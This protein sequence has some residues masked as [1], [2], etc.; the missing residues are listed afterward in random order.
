MA[1]ALPILLQ[2]QLS[3]SVLHSYRLIFIGYFGLCLSVAALYLFLSPAVEVANQAGLAP[4]RTKI[5]PESKRIIAKL[6]ALFSLDAFGGGFLTD[7][8][9]AYW[10]FR[11][12]WDR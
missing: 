1:A 7:S 4:T 12:L 3:F 11:R 8:L 2:R 9:V 5:A 10:F 6:T